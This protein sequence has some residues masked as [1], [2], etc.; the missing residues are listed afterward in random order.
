MLND[1]LTR[2]IGDTCPRCNAEERAPNQKWC[3]TCLDA[4]RKWR[5]NYAAEVWREEMHYIPYD[6]RHPPTTPPQSPFQPQGYC[7]KC[8]GSVWVDRGEGLWGCGGCGFDPSHP[9]QQ[10]PV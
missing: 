1:A 5:E 6:R 9:D 7:P 4:G 10:K 8:G 2:Y 3:A